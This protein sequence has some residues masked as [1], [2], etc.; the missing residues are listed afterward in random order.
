MTTYFIIGFLLFG[1]FI[2]MDYKNE[3][4]RFKTFNETIKFTPLVY[5][6][7]EGFGSLLFL[8][9]GMMFVW[10]VVFIVEVKEFIYPKLKHRRI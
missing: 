9:C 7:H 4:R 6:Q 10:P 1:F 3:K 8:L 2:V 5:L